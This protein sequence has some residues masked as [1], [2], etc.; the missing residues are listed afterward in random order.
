MLKDKRPSAASE[1]QP[2]WRETAKA[3]SGA[4]LPTSVTLVLLGALLWKPGDH[5]QQRKWARPGKDRTARAVPWG[6]CPQ[7]SFTGFPNQY[8]LKTKQDQCRY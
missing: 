2:C 7:D 4:S 3:T 6:T 5:A 1:E 8:R